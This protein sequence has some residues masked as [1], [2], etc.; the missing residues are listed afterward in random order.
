M[1]RFRRRRE[2][3]IDSKLFDEPDFTSEFAN[4]EHDVRFLSEINEYEKHFFRV[5]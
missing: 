5:D 4:D 1:K 2:F 3:K